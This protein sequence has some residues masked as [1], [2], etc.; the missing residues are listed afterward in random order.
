MQFKTCSTCAL[1]MHTEPAVYNAQPHGLGLGFVNLVL[2]TYDRTP[3]PGGLGVL[4]P[5]IHVV[6]TSMV[7]SSRVGGSLALSKGSYPV[8][9]QCL[10][11]L[12]WTVRLFIIVR[13]Q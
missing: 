1:R 11:N 10:E 5:C 9:G 4:F 7:D 6:L 8:G 2:T 12:A 3:D 13:Y